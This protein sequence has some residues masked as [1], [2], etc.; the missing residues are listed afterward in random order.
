MSRINSPECNGCLT[1]L[2][3]CPSKKSLSI[4]FFGNKVVRPVIYFF[5]VFMLFFSIIGVAQ[6]TGNWESNI[7]YENY[8]KIIPL[9]GKLTH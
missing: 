4:T 6:I 1:C 9:A 8:K 2:S 3:V 5:A 7:S